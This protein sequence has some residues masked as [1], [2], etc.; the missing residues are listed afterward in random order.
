MIKRLLHAMT[1]FCKRCLLYGFLLIGGILG[2]QVTHIEHLQQRDLNRERAFWKELSQDDFLIERS[3]ESRLGRD[4]RSLGGFASFGKESQKEAFII[5][6]LPAFAYSL[7]ME[8]SICSFRSAAIKPPVAST[9]S[10]EINTPTKG[11]GVAHALLEKKESQYRKVKKQLEAIDQWREHRLHSLEEEIVQSESC[12]VLSRL[13]RA[14]TYLESQY[15]KQEPIF[16]DPYYLAIPLTKKSTPPLLAG[17]VAG[18]VCYILTLSLT[19]ALLRAIGS[20]FK[21]V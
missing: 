17:L 4:D 12:H 3:S 13:I 16:S 7:S 8:N 19:S 10:R 18:F 1:R 6:P 20:L 21:R 14:A 5:P 9:T 2:S 15:K 11:H